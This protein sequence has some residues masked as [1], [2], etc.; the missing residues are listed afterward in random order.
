MFRCVKSQTR[1]WNPGPDKP[2]V[3]KASL[4]GGAE[5]DADERR[6]LY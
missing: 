3:Y 1:V 5:A 4:R 2:D 6:H